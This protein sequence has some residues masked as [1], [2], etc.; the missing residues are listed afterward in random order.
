MKVFR[1]LTVITRVMIKHGLGDVLE[2]LIGRQGKKEKGG[3]DKDLFFRSGFPSPKRIRLAL[4]E[5]GPSFIK[6]GQLMSTRADMFPPEYIEEFIKLQDRVPPVPFPEIKKVIED[7]L[8]GPLA[9]I[10]TEFHSEPI[11]AASV[12]QVHLAEL[13]TGERVAVKVIRPGIDKKIR[14]DIRL[15]VYLAERIEKNF[16][17]GR[18]LGVTQPGPGV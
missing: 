1:R 8:K 16:E 15:M 11:A 2:R 5:L 17:M 12:A 7:E 3:K 14:Q 13:P 9:G 10:F 6:L 18:I 4:E